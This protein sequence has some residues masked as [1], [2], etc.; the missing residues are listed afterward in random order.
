MVDGEGDDTCP[1]LSLGT[2]CNCSSFS[3]TAVTN[4]KRTHFC[5]EGEDGQKEKS[6]TER[7]TSPSYSLHIPVVQ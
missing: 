6:K 3:Q 4:L 2:S 7:S 5:V 1:F